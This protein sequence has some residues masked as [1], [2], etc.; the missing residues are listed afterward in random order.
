MSTFK[1]NEINF[2]YSLSRHRKG[3]GENVEVAGCR[4]KWEGEGGGGRGG[5]GGPGFCR[6]VYPQIGP[7][8]DFTVHVGIWIIKTPGIACKNI[9]IPV[10]CIYVTFFCQTK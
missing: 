2:R 9:P 1:Y 3:P 5:G 8:W 6:M 7:K 10:I 4:N